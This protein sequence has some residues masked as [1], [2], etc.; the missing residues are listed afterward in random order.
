[1]GIMEILGAVA[2]IFGALFGGGGQQQ[3]APVQ[4]KEQKPDET[5]E[6]LAEAR[7]RRRQLASR[8]GRTGLKNEG[9]QT[10]QVRSGLTIET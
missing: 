7:K 4:E 9:P 6:G 8:T 5:S 3:A 2:P 1:M 10:D